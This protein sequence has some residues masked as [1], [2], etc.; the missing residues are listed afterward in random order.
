M[1]SR[2]TV[3]SCLLFSLLFVP[4]FGIVF[5]ADDNTTEPIPVCPVPVAKYCLASPRA[6]LIGPPVWSS[7][8][9]WLPTGAAENFPRANGAIKVPV[10]TRVVF[11]L[12][13]ELEGIWYKRS[14][15]CLGTSLVLQLCQ[16][17]KNAECD[18]EQCKPAVNQVRPIAV[19]PDRVRP[20]KV[21]LCPWVTIG[22]DGA[23]DVRKGPSIGRAN[24]GVPVRFKK[25][26]IYYLRGI[27][28]TCARPYYP[29]PLEQWYDTLLD[30]N[31]TDGILPP[32]PSA[33]DRDVIYVRV[34][35][36]N[37]PIAEV[38]A[39]EELTDDPDVIHIKPM[40]K[41]IDSSEPTQIEIELEGN[42]VI[43]WIEAGYF[44]D[45]WGEDCELP[46]SNDQ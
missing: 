21:Q 27:V 34:N 26:G 38:E 31:D 33:V 20:D 14:Y 37:L 4:V 40:P 7:N 11:C 28:R 43:S 2:I 32:I 45:E 5:A 3:S 9:Y 13:R 36:V 41:D 46:L 12:S 23:K 16:A 24:V 6:C 8:A 18:C 30:E 39:E 29:R 17:C 42:D 44:A 15:G 1:L 22:K 25:T 10:G 19:N 35:V